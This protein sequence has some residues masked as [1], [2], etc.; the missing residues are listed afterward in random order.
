MDP[1]LIETFIGMVIIVGDH[2]MVLCATVAARSRPN[3][4]PVLSTVTRSTLRLAFGGE[5]LEGGSL[6][7]RRSLVCRETD[8]LECSR[9]C[10]D[11]SLHE[12]MHAVE[13]AGH[14]GLLKEILTGRLVHACVRGWRASKALRSRNRE[15]YQSANA[16]AAQRPRIASSSDTWLSSNIVPV[17]RSKAARAFKY[18]LWATTTVDLACARKLWY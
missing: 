11:E 8:I 12:V 5:Q 15:H 10:R 7:G 14:A 4:L 16:P 3:G 1:A 9:I 6:A 17:A 18:A 2:G 13:G